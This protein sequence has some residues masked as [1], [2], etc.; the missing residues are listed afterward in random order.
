M[1]GMLVV[2][3]ISKIRRVFPSEESHQDDQ[4]GAEGFPE[5]DPQSDPV[6]R[7]GVPL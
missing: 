5:G 2:E 3:T 1:F 4:P 6:W 7:D